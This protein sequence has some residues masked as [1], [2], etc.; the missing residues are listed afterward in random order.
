[1]TGAARPLPGAPRFPARSGRTGGWVARVLV[2]LS[3]VA[4]AAAAGASPT[5]VAVLG[6][7]AALLWFP[8]VG[9]L[10]AAA[11]RAGRWPRVAGVLVEWVLPVAAVLL[12][13]DLVALVALVQLTLVSHHASADR[14]P[15]T[16][17]AVAASLVVVGI[18]LPHLPLP[19]VWLVVY[20]AVLG[21]VVGPHLQAG[22]RRVE[23]ARAVAAEQ[24]R[25]E[26]L[27]TGVAE[28]VVVTGRGGRILRF[29][30]AAE[31]T[32]GCPSRAALGGRCT[33]VLGL[34]HDVTELDCSR[35]CAVLAEQ[36]RSGGDVEVWRRLGSGR[37]QPLL[38]TALP[39]GGDSGEVL[40]SFC[41]ITRLKQAEEAKTLFLASASHELKTPLTVIGGFAELLIAREELDDELRATALTT[42]LRRTEQLS[43]VVDRLLLASR[44]EAGRVVVDVQ[45]AALPPLL[46]GRV[47]ALAAA[48]GRDV[49]LEMPAALPAVSV[50][51]DAFVTVVDHLLDNALKYSPDGGPVEVTV[52]ER[53]RHVDVSVR[54][55]GIGMTA[56][57]RTRCFD[58]FW[59]G[60]GGNDRRFGGSGIGLYVVRSLVEAMGGTVGVRSLDDGTRFTVALRR[61]GGEVAGPEVDDQ[62]STSSIV[63]EFMHQAGLVEREGAP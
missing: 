28:A 54:D 18:G 4:G 32:F 2:A 50:D 34:R 51:A 41:D 17:L 55:H 11:S 3:V 53:E 60:E 6:Y 47:E 43:G 57:Q 21:G 1:M 19:G 27:L 5:S 14:L 52:V 40:H 49:R 13:G 59:Q 24:G 42:I 22:R 9:V 23:A 36:R 31:R 8:V 26:A 38:A 30:R 15:A 37:R 58:Q 12:V 29:N 16:V 10:E 46:R 20:A 35:G 44:I 61:V 56:E 7:G 62:G 48:T 63:V 33:A 39:L 45:D 25:S